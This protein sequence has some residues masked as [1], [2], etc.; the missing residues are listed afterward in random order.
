MPADDWKLELPQLRTPRLLLRAFELSDGPRVRELAGD[1]AIADTT[2][3]VPHPYPEG[4]AEAWIATHAEQRRNGRSVNFAVCLRDETDGNDAQAVL[5]GAMGLG[6]N[7]NLKAAELGY[8]IGVPYHNR[9]IA[10][11]A[12]RVVLAFGFR[13]IGLHR[14][15]AHHLTRN[16]ASGRVMQK[17]GMRSEG[18]R[19][20]ATPWHGVN[21]PPAGHSGFEDMVVYAMLAT[22]PEAGALIP[23]H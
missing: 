4:A 7:G 10:S 19:R 3:H 18:I 11:E 1:A 21:P 13:E 9:G 17:A 22:D 5:V 23:Q 8:W 14:I 16:P 15:F 6:V 12:T 20:G 2:I